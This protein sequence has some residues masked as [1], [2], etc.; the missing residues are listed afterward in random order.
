M[1]EQSLQV[2]WPSPTQQCC[3]DQISSLVCGVLPSQ[4][5]IATSPAAELL[6]LSCPLLGPVLGSASGQSGFL[7]P[8][9]SPFT[10]VA[11]CQSLCACA[12]RLEWLSALTAVA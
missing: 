4:G 12:Y 1:D 3:V 8:A 11:S 2:G 6:E 9:E 5:R 7:F 10:Q